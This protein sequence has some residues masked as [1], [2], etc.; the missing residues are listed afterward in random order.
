MKRC[1]CIRMIMN[2]EEKQRLGL[3]VVPDIHFATLHIAKE[4]NIFSK[5]NLDITVNE[6][7]GGTG[8]LAKILSESHQLNM[9]IGLTD[10]LIAAISKGAN[11]RIVGTFV[12][13]PMK[14][15][16]VIRGNDSKL[17]SIGNL[18]GKTFGITKLGG[19]AHINTVLITSKEGWSEKNGD[20]NQI[21]R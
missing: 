17:E 19:G 8:E 7:A 10:G 20:F 3:G 4:R 1:I 5:Y 2:E 9:G 6:C 12:D 18:G 13:S 21:P 15:V 11:F 16:V 14:W